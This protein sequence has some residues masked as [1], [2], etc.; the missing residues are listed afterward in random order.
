MFVVNVRF[1]Y[2]MILGLHKRKS[3]LGWCFHP[4]FESGPMFQTWEEKVQSIVIRTAYCQ[5]L[6][7]AVSGFK[8]D[9]VIV[10]YPKDQLP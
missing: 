5:Q 4:S 7:V 6:S 10:T 3:V 9:T 8:N 2:W 1:L